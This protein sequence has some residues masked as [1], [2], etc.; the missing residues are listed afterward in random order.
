MDL[1]EAPS[2]LGALTP[3]W[4]QLA[5]RGGVRALLGGPIWC[6]LWLGCYGAALEATPQIVALRDGGALVGVAPLYT[7]TSKV[8]PGVKARELRFIGDAGPRPPGFDLLAA[9]GAE[10]Q[11]ADALVAWLLRDGAAWDVIDFAPL[12]DPSRVRAFLAERIDAAGRRVESQP[13]GATQVVTLAAAALSPALL[14]T[15]SPR[16][17]VFDPEPAALAKGLTALRRL[18]RL[19]WAARDEQSPLAD[20]EGSRMLADVLARF[21]AQAGVRLARVDGAHG[22]PSAVGLVIDDDNRAVL[23]AL[24]VDPEEPQAGS[25]LVAAE[26]RA[27]ALRGMRALDV[28]AGASEI[29]PPPLP[30]STRHALRLR[31]FNTTPAGALARTMASVRRRADAAKEAPGA[32]AA[33]ARAAWARVREAAS[34]VAG[35]ERLHLYRGELWTRGP[36]PPEAVRTELLDADAFA[37]L[38]EPARADLLARLELDELACLDRWQ[39]G[40]IAVLARVAGRPAG[41]AWAA[42]SAT[43]VGELGREIRPAPSECYIH[44]VFVAPDARGKGVAPVML[45]ALAGHLRGLDVYRAWALIRPS[46]VASVRAFEKAAYAA[47]CDV[48]HAHLG[49]AERLVLRPSDPAA[50]RLLGVGEAKAP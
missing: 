42:R 28:V 48:I 4:M 29:E 44:D 1:I 16:A 22:E 49:A 25:A 36:A 41:I 32:A 50:E 47:V 9:P 21:G 6:E 15:P 13:A 12:R 11:V 27:A 14:P 3:E 19:E 37:A 7:R 26:A 20:A 8:G 18:S 38:G 33:G 39:A 30:T 43:M 23:V 35:Y 34:S 17:G 5:E 45:E 10:A 31:A 40:T 46:N 24:A 2:R